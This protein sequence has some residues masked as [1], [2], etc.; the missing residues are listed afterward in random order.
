MKE[1]V[2]ASLVK[3]LYSLFSNNKRTK[4]KN[5]TSTKRGDNLQCSQWGREI[6]FT[7][8]KSG[9]KIAYSYRYF[10]QIPFDFEESASKWRPRSEMRSRDAHNEAIAER[11]KTLGGV[12]LRK[13]QSPALRSQTQR[14]PSELTFPPPISILMLKTTIPCIHDFKHVLPP[15]SECLKCI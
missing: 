12:P 9:K 7:K 13:L 10:Q 5:D 4:R 8:K 14:T 6:L 1:E 11:R 2:D 3:C 15:H